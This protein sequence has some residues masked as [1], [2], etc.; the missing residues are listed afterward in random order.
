MALQ[1]SGQIKLSEIAAEFGGSAPH[2]LS[3]Y[4]GSDTVPSS[5]QISFSNFYGTSAFT[6]FAQGNIGV[7]TRNIKAG[8]DQK[9]YSNGNT[10]AGTGGASFGSISN[11]SISN[12]SRTIVALYIQQGFQAKLNITFSGS[13]TSWTTLT[14]NGN[15]SVNRTAA[16]LNTGNQRYEWNGNYNLPTTF[17]IT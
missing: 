8:T 11:S 15:Y 1:S 13:Y 17:T 6:G 12:A 7:G 10:N 16:N 5:G 9:G 14:I 4:Y 3:E 2:A